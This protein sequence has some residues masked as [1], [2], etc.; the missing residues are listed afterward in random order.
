MN[1]F[2]FKCNYFVNK[3]ILPTYKR[4][5]SNYPCISKYTE[6]TSF[7]LKQIPHLLYV[8]FPNS[9]KWLFKF[10]TGFQNALS[11]LILYLEFTPQNKKDRKWGKIHAQNCVWVV[12]VC[13]M[14]DWC[15]IVRVV[16]VCYN[17]CCVLKNYMVTGA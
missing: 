17:V 1:R 13:W 9:Q 7:Y 16:K 15:M 4:I 8:S 3:D 6:T 10:Q 2:S 5:I 11:G 14:N 12:D